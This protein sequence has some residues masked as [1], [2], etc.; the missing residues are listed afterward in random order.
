MGDLG[1][2]DIALSLLIIKPLA[3]LFPGPGNPGA[4]TQN[5]SPLLFSK[6]PLQKIHRTRHQPAAAAREWKWREGSE[7]GGRHWAHRQ[8]LR[9]RNCT[10]PVRVRVRGPSERCGEPAD[11]QFFSPGYQ[12][13]YHEWSPIHVHKFSIYIYIC[14]KSRESTNLY[15]YIVYIVCFRM[16]IV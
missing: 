15:V 7:V 10:G 6:L 8:N 3:V 2:D 12:T 4:F 16:R 13:K 9:R 14:N 1:Q 5:S 11:R